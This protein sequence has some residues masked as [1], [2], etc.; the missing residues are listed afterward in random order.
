[1]I[2]DYSFNSEGESKIQVK[3]DYQKKRFF[4]PYFDRFSKGFNTKLYLQIFLVLFVIYAVFYSDCFRVK[5]IDVRGTDLIAPDEI[6]QLIWQDLSHWTWHLFPSNNIL[7]INKNNL[8]SEISKK[9]ALEKLEIHKGWHSLS[10]NLKEKVSYLLVYNSKSYYLISNDGI[11]TKEVAQSDLQNR[12]GKLPL[13]IDNKDINIGS[14]I[15]PAKKV[16]YILELNKQLPTAGFKITSYENRT[17]DDVAAVTSEGWSMTFDFNLSISDSIN[18]LK[19]VLN[20]KI[21][22]RKG[23]HYIDLRFGNKVFYQ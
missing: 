17:G 5:S 18:N 12:L 7:F 22:D 8:K 6:R 3:K 2:E 13:V 11:A 14:A 20:Q 23:L 9:Y 19:L 1:M 10:I 16:N 15:L 21:K 4:N